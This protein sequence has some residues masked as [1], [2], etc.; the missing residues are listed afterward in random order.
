MGVDRRKSFLASMA[1]LFSGVRAKAVSLI[2]TRARG[3]S[4]ASN[5]LPQHVRQNS[6]VPVVI[7]FNRRIDSA[8]RRD[9]FN[10]SIRARDL[11]RQFLL[12]AQLVIQ[13]NNIERLR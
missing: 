4:S 5:D 11:Q 8:T 13:P 9:F 1:R 6:T 2:S 10:L 7:N 12:R 3:S